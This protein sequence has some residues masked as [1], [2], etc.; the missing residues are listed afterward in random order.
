MNIKIGGTHRALMHSPK[1]YKIHILAIVDDHMVVFKY[2]G[3]HEQWWHYEILSRHVVENKIKWA[4]CRT[5]PGV[6]K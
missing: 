4:D 6:T 1:P 2:Y 3:R 5:P